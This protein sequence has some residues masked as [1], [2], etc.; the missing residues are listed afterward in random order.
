MAVR[1]T[2]SSRSGLVGCFFVFDQLQFDLA[3]VSG[4]AL[5]L[6]G[7][8]PLG[9]HHLIVFDESLGILVIAIELRAGVFE[10][11]DAIDLVADDFAASDFDFDGGPLVPVEGGGF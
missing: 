10:D 11:G 9:E 7:D 5:C 1:R 8:V 6:D 2:P 3:K 4:V